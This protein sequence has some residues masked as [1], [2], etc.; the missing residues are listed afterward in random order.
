MIGL[1]GQ[2]DIVLNLSFRNKG[3]E[4]SEVEDQRGQR[5]GV[6]KGRKGLSLFARILDRIL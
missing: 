4:R 1:M 6:Q 2:K 3:A 5:R